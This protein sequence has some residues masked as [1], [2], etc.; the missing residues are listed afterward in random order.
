MA[1]A[2]NN[3][4]TWKELVQQAKNNLA[5][6][7][8]NLSGASIPDAFNGTDLFVSKSN[9]TVHKN[10]KPEISS[11]ARSNKAWEVVSKDVVLN[12]FEAFLN[13]KKLNS[14]DRENQIVS[15]RLILNF[16]ENL[17]LFYM[18]RLVVVYSPITN[19]KK[20]YYYNNGSS[21][22]SWAGAVANVGSEASEPPIGNN[23]IKTMLSNI[24]KNLKNKV[25]TYNQEYTFWTSSSSSSCSSSSS[26]SSSSS[27]WTIIHQDL[28]LL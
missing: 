10:H 23:E 11:W 16:F 5:N 3:T 6:S 18:N 22:S 15:T 21:Y 1:I 13:N 28:S 26:S 12:D 25:K 19:E 14:T 24:D 2:S 20:L 9:C 27:C 4:I 8:E 7:I 17:S